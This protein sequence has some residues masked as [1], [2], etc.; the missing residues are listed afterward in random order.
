MV[1]MLLLIGGAI[2]VARG[3]RH[4]GA[5]GASE[6]LPPSM[7]PGRGGPQGDGADDTGAPDRPRPRW[8]SGFAA[9]RVLAMLAFVVVWVLL[10]RPEAL[11]GTATWVL[12]SGN[13]M[14]PRLHDGDLVFARH[15]SDYHRGDVIAFRIP[16]GDV[17]AGTIVIHRIVGGD[18]RTGFA[19][20]GD[21]RARADLWRPTDA[22]VA[23]RLVATVPAV[24]HVL[25]LLRTPLILAALS[26]LTAFLSVPGTR[27]ARPR[28]APA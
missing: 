20:R 28:P 24:G 27:G 12:V 9:A 17:G 14:E 18:G 8:R 19:T 26:A 3:R 16:R 23:G 7:N 2:T 5:T 1:A 15:S 4:D 11:G 6:T 10:L 13:S 22:Q 25:R 21:N